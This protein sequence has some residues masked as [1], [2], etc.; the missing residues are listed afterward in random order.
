MQY[1]PFIIVVSVVMALILLAGSF[2]AGFI[3]GHTLNS[4]SVGLLLNSNLIPGLRLQDPVPALQTQSG[5]PQNLKELFKPFWQAW[6]VATTKYVKQPV[7]QTALMRGA[8]KGMLDSLGDEHTSYLDPEMFKMANAQ[9]Q[10]AQYTGIGAWVD[11]TRK[12]LTIVSPMPGSPAEKAG[13]KTNDQIIAIDGQDMTGV[14]GEVAHQKVLGPEGSVVTLTILR[15]GMVPFDVKVTRAAI[16][17]PSVESKMLDNNIAYVHLF[18]FGSSTDKELRDALTKLLLQKPAGLV[19]DLRNNPGGYLNT[20]I[21]VA[22][23]F[24]GKGPIVY[25]QYGNGTKDSLEAKPGGVALNIPLVV[26]INQG[27]ASASEIVAGAIQDLGRGKLV[28][29]TSYG[30]GSVQTF[31]TLADNQGAIRVTSAYWLTPNG[32]QINKIGLTPDTVVQ[33]TDQDRTAGQ[34]PQLAKA[35]EILMQK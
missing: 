10:G 17:A 23:E 15:Q 21:D 8:I 9:L 1:K 3:T 19:L 24:I 31:E 29:M 18:T 28:G 32:R 7:D 4:P 2:S 35:V 11:A 13:L 30:K 14:A 22:S 5:T 12:Y 6:D 27:S 25:Q 16:V 26:L 34:D 20:A 33:L